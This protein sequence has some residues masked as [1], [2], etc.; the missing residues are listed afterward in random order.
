MTFLK[1]K[2]PSVSGAGYYILNVLRG[3]NVISL[4]TAI[5]ACI[6]MLVR[7]FQ[8]SEFFL[9]DGVNHVFT[10]ALS[11]CLIITEFPVFRGYLTDNW[12]LLSPSSGLVTLG[13]LMLV[14]GVSVLGNLNKAAT[15]QSTLGLSDWQVVI[16]SGILCTILGFANIIANYTFQKKSQGLTAR[17]VRSRSL[18]TL[19]AYNN[20]RAAALP[21]PL[22][23]VKISDPIPMNPHDIEFGEI[24]LEH[25]RR[26]AS[27]VYPSSSVYTR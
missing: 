15:D 2:R 13:V 11:L 17:M 7:T 18:E 27:S 1:L 6:L 3:M 21:K 19:P 8:N 26:P 12:P 9:F 20:A 5:I 4:I 24:P 25:E 14:V 16:S 23:G 10:A 22:N